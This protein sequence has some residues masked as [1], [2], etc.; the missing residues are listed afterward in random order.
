VTINFHGA[1]GQERAMSLTAIQPDN[2]HPPAGEAERRARVDLAA[3]FRLAVRN[4]WHEGIANHISLA[5]SDDGRR[6]LM[7]PQ[8]RHWSRIRASDLVLLDADGSDDVVGDG[9]G[10]VDPTAWHIHSRIHAGNPAARCVLHVH[11]LHATALACLAGY[12]L[13]MIDQNAMRFHGRIAYD[14]DFRGMALDEQEG[15]RIGGALEPGKSVLFMANHGV[16]VVGRSVAETF[17]ETY[18]L[19]RACQLQLLALST[20]RPLHVVPDEVAALTCRQWLEFPV[21]ACRD[22]FEE[23]KALLDRDEPDYRD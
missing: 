15:R 8:G 1:F 2:R 17:D 16:T 20:G 4:D 11:M 22:H 6:F 14:D 13:Q 10:K 23:M 18:Y 19:E 3:L 12:R 7:N 9:A 21:D 5:V